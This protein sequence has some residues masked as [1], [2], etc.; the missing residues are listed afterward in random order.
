MQKNTRYILAIC[1]TAVVTVLLLQFYWIKNYY[2]INRFTFE[3][4]VNMAFEDALKKEFSLRC[5]TIQQLI[6]NKLMDTTE[7]KITSEYDDK[8]KRY[9]YTVAN[10]HNL[11][12][13]YQ[14]SSFSTKKLNKALLPKDTIFRRKIAES[15][16]YAMRS[17][18]L[19]NHI[20]YYH[21]QNLGKYAVDNIEKYN[22]D[23]TRLRPVLIHYLAERQI[24]V[25]F[26][27]YLRE[28][29][30]T[31]NRSHFNPKL[32]RLYPIITKAYPT[33]KQNSSE[34]Y[35][36][37]LFTDPFSYIM[38]QMGLTLIGSIFLIAVVASS[39]FYL[40][41]TVYREKKVSAIKND[42]ISNIT[43]EFK[44]PIATVSA[45]IEALTSFDVLDDPEKTRRYL[46]HSKNELNRL[47]ALVDKVLNI[48][49]YE[50]Q[51]FDIKPEHLNVDNTIS[52]ILKECT[53]TSAR[54]V[55]YTYVNLS[56]VTQV[57]ADQ[58]YFQHTLINVIDNAIK[59]SDKQ[60]DIQVECTL[61]QGHLVI[62]VKDSGTGI[63][64][65]NLPHIFEKF[66]RVP[67]SHHHTKGHGL[68]LSYVKSII[69]KHKGW[70]KMESEFGKGST[71]YLAWP[72]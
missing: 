35:V 2:K 41:R 31:F 14:S 69:E 28:S 27:F 22:F 43:H 58:L 8:K 15:F 34:Q 7:F 65:G 42:F 71:L 11:H 68:G 39:L 59:Y 64:A 33:Y 40:L 25:P 6:A 21:T 44:T 4:E 55:K 63:S 29:D 23:T 20:V 30:S 49:L 37:V 24:N 46:H 18:D 53:L 26:K 57:Y 48:S 51:Q 72:L 10:A 5:D 60:I 70:C 54:P 66:Y 61:R 52:A 19:E 12:D 17:E 1:I 16:A 62:A 36:R 45:A 67:S 9:I 47:S 56:G 38:A 13:K 50:N 3:K 32:T